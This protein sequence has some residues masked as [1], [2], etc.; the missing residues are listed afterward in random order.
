MPNNETKQVDEI[1]ASRRAMLIGGT[2]ALAAIAFTPAQA[3]A[4][5]TVSSY[6]DADILNFA[7]N[8]EYLE[9]NFY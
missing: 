6:T 4:A 9:A 1:I 2:A 8:L 3:K 5:A 7:L